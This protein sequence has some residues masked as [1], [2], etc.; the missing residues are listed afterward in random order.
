MHMSVITVHIIA[1]NS[2][3]AIMIMKCGAVS[4]NSIPNSIL[5][6]A[7]NVSFHPHGQTI[8]QTVGYFP[9]VS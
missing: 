4:F 7:V 3:H 9:S 1:S 5:S 6:K 8:S 2:K